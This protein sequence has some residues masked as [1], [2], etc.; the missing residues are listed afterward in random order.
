MIDVTAPG[1]RGRSPSGIRAHR[2]GH[3]KPWDKTVVEGIPCTSVA[4][5]L[6]D[7]AGVVRPDELRNAIVQAEMQR[8]FDLTALHEVI[9]RSRGR[10]GVARLRLA[11]DEHDPRSERAN[12]GLE[13][14]FLSMCRSARLP[15]PEVNAQL[16]LADRQIVVDFLWRDR[17]LIV[18]TDDRR[19][20]HTVFAFERD[21]RR[22]QELTLAG[23]QVTRCT[24]QQVT[25]EP[26][27]LIRMLRALLLPTG[28]FP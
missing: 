16:D 19:S 3:L 5:T 24:W 15:S 8:V 27:R 17:R 21:R 23:W 6:L 25:R 10:R 28:R 26:D 18:E 22:D 4:R 20:H 12:R 2:H 9:G 11:I 1:R 7:L 14:T 13:R